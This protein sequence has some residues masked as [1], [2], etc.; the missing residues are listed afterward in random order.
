MLAAKTKNFTDTRSD[1]PQ[2]PTEPP[3]GPP[4]SGWVQPCVAAN[5][6]GTSGLQSSP[7]V[8]RV[9]EVG[10]VGRVTGMHEFGAMVWIWAMHAGIGAVLCGP[11]V[12]FSRRRVHWQWWELA[13][14]VAPFLVW[15]A[16]MFSELSTGR[17]SLSNLVEPFFLSA[18]LPLAAVVRVLIGPRAGERAAAGSLL[19]ALCVLA[20]GVF[21]IVPS[22]QE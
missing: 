1:E 16:L 21:F 3:P 17:K 6:A 10:W 22:L 12:F 15:S 11:I 4:Q 19:A 9:A 8:R 13:A 14:F 2:R 7:P 20:A 5:P 18:A